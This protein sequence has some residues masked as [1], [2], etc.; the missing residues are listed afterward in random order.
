M[1]TEVSTLDQ[2]SPIMLEREGLDEAAQRQQRGPRGQRLAAAMALMQQALALLDEADDADSS[3]VHLDLAIERLRDVI[4][5]S[6]RFDTMA[7]AHDLD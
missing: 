2:T 3:S 6:S 5:D 7:I 1:G 4:G